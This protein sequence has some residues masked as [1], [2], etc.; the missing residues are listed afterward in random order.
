MFKFVTSKGYTFMKTYLLQIIMFQGILHVQEL[1]VVLLVIKCPHH[2]K[3]IFNPMF[4]SLFTYIDLLSFYPLAILF[5]T[6]S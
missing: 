4:S 6:K 1:V 3:I 5:D 2:Q